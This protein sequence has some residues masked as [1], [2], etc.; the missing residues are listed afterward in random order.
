L[1][2]ILDEKVSKRNNGVS[3]E[4]GFHRYLARLAENTLLILLVDFID[5]LLDSIKSKTKLGHDFYRQVRNSHQEILNCLIKKD[6]PGA[7]LAMTQ[8]LLEVDR[9][10]SLV[11]GSVPFDPAELNPHPVLKPVRGKGFLATGSRRNA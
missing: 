7:A 9:Y 10:L 11:T 5:N 2:K 6:G 1:E 4:I 3:K 8:D